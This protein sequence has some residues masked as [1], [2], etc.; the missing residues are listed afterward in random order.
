M[1]P[2]QQRLYDRL[3]AGGFQHSRDGFGAAYRRGYF[4]PAGRCPY[5]RTSLAEAAWRAGRDQYRADERDNI[6]RERG[7]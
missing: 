6:K 3:K 1:T 7:R 2:L 5:V 4:R